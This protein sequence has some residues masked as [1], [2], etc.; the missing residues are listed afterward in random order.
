MVCTLAG[1]KK[2]DVNLSVKI[3]SE[4]NLSR[5][6]DY[7]ADLSSL[8]YTVEDT[9]KILGI[10]PTKVWEMIGSGKIRSTKI[11]RR[12]LVIADSLKQLLC[13]DA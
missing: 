10:G 6:S 13:I 9:C 2:N 1:L 3:K 7:K 4:D 11:G 8:A 12:R 5:R